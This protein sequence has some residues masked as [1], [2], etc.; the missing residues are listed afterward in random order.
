MSDLSVKYSKPSRS[1]RGYYD[2]PWAGEVLV[3]LDGSPLGVA[4]GYTKNMQLVI[5]K[6][7]STI[8][9]AP[10]G[11][12][13]TKESPAKVRALKNAGY[14]ESTAKD[15]PT[16]F[17]SGEDFMAYVY[18]TWPS[19]ETL[20]EMQGGD[21]WMAFIEGDP[22]IKSATYSGS[23]GMVS[24]CT[25]D[26]EGEAVE[27]NESVKVGDE[28][29][30]FTSG[31]VTEINGDRVIIHH[32][33][34][35][36]YHDVPASDI[37]PEDI[38]KKE[39]LTPPISVLN[40]SDFVAKEA[41][42]DRVYLDNDVWRTVILDCDDPES[43]EI[44]KDEEH[45]QDVAYKGESVIG[46]Y[47]HDLE[48][49]II[50]EADDQTFDNQEE[51]LKS[52]KPDGI[53]SDDSVTLDQDEDGA[54][55]V[56]KDKNGDVLGTFTNID[57]KSKGVK[58]SESEVLGVP[59]KIENLLKDYDCIEQPTQKSPKPNE[60]FS[61]PKFYPIRGAFHKVKE[62]DVVMYATYPGPEFAKI[63]SK[64]SGAGMG[65][66]Q[67]EDGKEVASM[68]VAAIYR[69]KVK[70][71]SVVLKPEVQ[72]RWKELEKMDFNDLADL[73][74]E[75]DSSINAPYDL[76]RKDLIEVVVDAEFGKGSSMGESANSDISDLDWPEPDS[77]GMEQYLRDNGWEET[78]GIALWSHPD[79]SIW[80]D[81]NTGAAWTHPTRPHRGPFNNSYDDFLD[82]S[83]TV[84]ELK[85]AIEKHGKRVWEESCG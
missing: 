49:G 38:V 29:H 14:Y 76:T 10:F 50:L 30:G 53:G 33:Q 36:T 25:E 34:T 67:T 56:A 82:I 46:I 45:R 83:A 39:S 52:V 44:K 3:N 11:F 62:G 1:K 12:R 6:E 26:E 32:T 37:K 23:N 28:V 77:A 78:G 54:V 20:V 73:A 31:I 68:D 22:V 16:E 41:Q 79:Y 57:G 64:K 70:T 18:N 61:Y 40:K 21:D 85:A 27:L 43:V 60:H 47:D 35:D 59:S 66:L 75:L 4:L 15:H 42:K 7:D 71:E 48:A 2:E 72:A 58:V 65:I 69:P 5:K 13:I 81:T 63:I 80:I 19:Q 24:W 74:A 55:T 8:E 51:W 9:L 17:D 84:D